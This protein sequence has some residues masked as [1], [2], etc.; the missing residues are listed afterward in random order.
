M[1]DTHEDRLTIYAD[2]VCPFCYL[3]H[4]SLSQYRE[5]HEQEILIDWQPF[6]LRS[7]KRGPDGEIDHGVD[8]GKDDQYF[9]QARENVR[10]LQQEYGVEMKQAIAREVDSLNAQLASMY[11]KEHY[12]NRWEAVDEAIY[13]ALWQDG[14]DIGDRDVLAEICADAGLDADEVL[15]ASEAKGLREH[16]E[17]RFSAARERGVTGVPTFVYEGRAACGAIPPEQLERLIDGV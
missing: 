16:L 17:E 1:S 3:G 10:R 14:R 6:D 4:A 12:P 5:S 8:D 2:Y 9:E 13:A 7:G 11:V 15:E